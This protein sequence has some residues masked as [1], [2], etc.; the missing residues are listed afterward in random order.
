MCSWFV[1][2]TQLTLQKN[3]FFCTSNGYEGYFIFMTVLI[4]TV[5]WQ[6]CSSRYLLD[7][8]APML[9]E[10]RYQ[11]A[12]CLKH[13]LQTTTLTDQINERRE[14]AV[15][16][17]RRALPRRTDRARRQQSENRQRSECPVTVSPEKARVTV[18][19]EKARV[20]QTKQPFGSTRPTSHVD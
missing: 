4:H 14:A 8:P 13:P 10:C 7:Y 5:I 15:V 3:S 12:V 11:P 20:K 6:L 18:S 1:D 19:P 2:S 17:N 9:C 16:Q